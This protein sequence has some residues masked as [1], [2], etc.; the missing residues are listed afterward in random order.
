MELTGDSEKMTGG[1]KMDWRFS[2]AE[3]F[4]ESRNL[5]ET[6]KEWAGRWT[7]ER[8]MPDVKMMDRVQV[9]AMR[10]SRG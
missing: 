3:G 4:P 2:G 5:P 7:S 1:K 9:L 10:R 6:S 8:R